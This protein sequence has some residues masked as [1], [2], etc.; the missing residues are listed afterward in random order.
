VFDDLKVRKDRIGKFPILR[1][2]L[3]RLRPE[4][5]LLQKS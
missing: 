5:K 4:I 3:E 1:S 2:I